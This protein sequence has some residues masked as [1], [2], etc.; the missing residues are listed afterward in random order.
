MWPDKAPLSNA[1]PT[2]VWDNLSTESCSNF[3]SSS[4]GSLTNAAWVEGLSPARLSL[5]IALQY[6]STLI[7]CRSASSINLATNVAGNDKAASIGGTLLSRLIFIRLYSWFYELIWFNL[8]PTEHRTAQTLIPGS[9][10]NENQ[11]LWIFFHGEIACFERES[12]V[13]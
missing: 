7:P 9:I 2:A 12:T 6:S 1:L 3:K 8:E 4:D 13:K 5:S 11:L 10:P